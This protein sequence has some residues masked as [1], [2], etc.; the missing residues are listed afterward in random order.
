MNDV[1]EEIERLVR[2]LEQQRDELRLKMH[3]AKADGRDEWNR[4]ERQWEEVRPRVAQAGAVLGDTTRQV[5]S[6]LKLALEEIGRGYDRLR[7]LF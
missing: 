1:R 6:A 4:L 3:L 2:R 5:G 7:K